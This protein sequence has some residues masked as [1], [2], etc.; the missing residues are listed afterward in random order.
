MAKPEG[1]NFKAVERKERTVSL[2]ALTDGS[3]FRLPHVTFEDAVGGDDTGGCFYHVDGPEK[4]GLIPVVS[5][6]RQSRRKLPKETVVH[7]HNI[8]ISI[9]PCQLV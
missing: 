6:D 3:A 9:H 8:E 7:P 1:V 5:F 4:E 2:S